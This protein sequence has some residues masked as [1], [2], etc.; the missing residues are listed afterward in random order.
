M[1]TASRLIRPAAFSEPK[2]ASSRPSA[3]LTAAA[4][5]P[6]AAHGGLVEVLHDLLGDLRVHLAEPDDLGGDL[7]RLGVGELRHHLGG[8]A[9]AHLHQDDGG[10]LGTG[11]GGFG[12]FHTG[13]LSSIRPRR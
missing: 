1:L 10:P 4:G 5:L 11:E 9:P 12:E 3:K 6:G 7:L 13:C 8:V 2:D